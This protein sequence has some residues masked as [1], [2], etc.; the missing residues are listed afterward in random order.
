MSEE[1]AASTLRAVTNW[2]RYAEYFAYDE[3]ADLFT[4]ENPS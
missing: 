4:L 1:T 3:D 2:A